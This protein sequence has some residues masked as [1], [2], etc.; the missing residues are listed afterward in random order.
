M[1][2]IVRDATSLY[3]ILVG[4][5]AVLV[6]RILS[7]ILVLVH[8][9]R[10]LLSHVL[11]NWL[12]LAITGQLRLA[13]SSSLGLEAGAANRSHSLPRLPLLRYLPAHTIVAR[14]RG[15]LVELDVVEFDLADVGA[16]YS[17]LVV[18]L[19]K[20]LLLLSLPLIVLIVYLYHGL[21]A[22]INHVNCSINFSRFLIWTR[23][24]L[25]PFVLRTVLNEHDFALRWIDLRAFAVLVLGRSR[26]VQMA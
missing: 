3:T 15:A 5:A 23:H 8:L 9:H 17:T 16:A 7:K 22:L 11:A 20:C 10:K 24:V 18:V 13:S 1:S 2:P 21:V 26:I 19:L 6:V 12:L 25:R 4:V 14:R